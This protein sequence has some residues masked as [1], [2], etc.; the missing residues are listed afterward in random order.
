MRI[1]AR[2]YLACVRNNRISLLFSCNQ[3]YSDWLEGRTPV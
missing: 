3:P 1:A 2:L